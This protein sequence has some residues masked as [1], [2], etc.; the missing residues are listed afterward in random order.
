MLRKLPRRHRKCEFY[1]DGCNLSDIDAEINNNEYLDVIGILAK[2]YAKE[3][4]YT[5]NHVSEFKNSEYNIIIYKNS[6]CITEL[7]LT[8]PKVD[9]KNCYNKV[10][11]YY[12]I[13]EDLIIA[14][15]EK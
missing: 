15:A 4:S 2:T 1:T 3:F 5:K 12:N 9:F 11:E 10:K 7:S 13:S 8:M 6:D 14:I